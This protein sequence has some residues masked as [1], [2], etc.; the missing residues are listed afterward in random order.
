MEINNIACKD[1]V[2]LCEKLWEETNILKK[3]FSKL[4]TPCPLRK[5]ISTEKEGKRREVIPASGIQFLLHG[6]LAWPGAGVLAALDNWSALND[7]SFTHPICTH[8]QTITPDFWKLKVYIVC[9]KLFGVITINKI[10][11]AVKNLI[12][13]LFRW[14]YNHYLFF[15]SLSLSSYI[16]ISFICSKSWSLK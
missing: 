15:L 1:I 6:T 8:F 12:T 10:L 9:D 4:S 11:R 2:S 5:T 3:L 7:V 16:M 14:E 13:L